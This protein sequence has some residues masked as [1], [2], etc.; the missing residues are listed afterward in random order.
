MGLIIYGSHIIAQFLE[1][2]FGWD[3]GVCLITMIIII[4]VLSIS[5]GLQLIM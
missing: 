3:Y 4:I 5:I 1:F 2:K